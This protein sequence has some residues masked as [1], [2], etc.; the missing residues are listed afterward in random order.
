MLRPQRILPHTA[1]LGQLVTRL[2]LRG[3]HTLIQ[4][5]QP[6][7]QLVIQLQQSTILVI[8]LQRHIQL[9]LTRHRGL[10]EVLQSLRLRPGLHIGQLVNRQLRHILRHILH[11]IGLSMLQCI[12]IVNRQLRHMELVM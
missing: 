7:I 6:V 5:S 9:R 1:R 10:V 8:Q 4:V 12:I 2:Q 3:L 11:H